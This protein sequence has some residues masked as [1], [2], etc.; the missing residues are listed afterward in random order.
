MTDEADSKPLQANVSPANALTPR[1][2]LASGVHAQ[3]G[4]YALLLGSGVSRAAGISTGWE[5]VSHLI[6][7]IAAAADPDD[8]ESH[9]LA[10]AD[11]E[12]W[13][14]AN[15]EGPLGYSSLLGA[16][17]PSSASRQGLLSEYFVPSETDQADGKKVPTPAHRAI[18]KLVKDGW[19]RVLVTTNFDK[20][21]EQAL[22]AESVPY[23]TVSRPDAIAA[24]SPLA[25]PPATVIK[26]HG[27]WTDLEF[28][29][30]LEELDEYPEPWRLLLGQVFNEYGLLASGWSADWDRALVR[31][32]ESTT[33]RY[34]LYWDSRSSKGVAATNLLAQ[35]GG[36]VIQSDSADALFT[37]L[38]ASIEALQRLAEPPLTTAMAVARLKRALPDPLRRI[39][40][41]DLLNAAV[42]A[43]LP[44]VD[45]VPE[46]PNTVGVLDSAL[47]SLF[48]ATKPL[49]TLLVTVVRFDDGTHNKLLINVLQRLLEARRKLISLTSFDNAQHY[50]ALLALRA[51]SIEAVRVGRDDLIVELLTTPRWKD[52]FNRTSATSAAQVLHLLRVVDNNDANRLP[53]WDG[54]QWRYPTSHL[55]KA[56]LQ[57]FFADQNVDN[58]TYDNLCD[59]V[60]YRTGFVQHLIDDQP[61]D[62]R[63]CGGEFVLE[64]R[65]EPAE[66]QFRESIA[67]NGLSAW[68]DLLGDGDLDANL[69]SYGETLARYPSW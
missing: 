27:D 18:A 46:S 30:T 56:E 42:D 60:E 53:R 2:M 38:L 8:T 66:Q 23:Q 63:P 54:Q 22:A 41:D 34:P 24:M 57:Q 65:R 69:A 5:I 36:H 35:H 40:L 37:D 49:L 20:L 28:R 62:L 1:V 50:P 59:D 68:A 43:V 19:V 26:L 21:I 10:A 11:P 44:A 16:I 31:I 58:R 48:E 7:K 47:G 52:V 12:A 55:L 64:R 14:A 3:P 25:H 6:Q 33:R 61:G 39:E 17:G 67:R 45:Q 13:W 29:N 51:M 4:V 32:L 15:G 9:K